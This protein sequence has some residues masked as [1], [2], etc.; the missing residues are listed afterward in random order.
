MR[1]INKR[2]LL[3]LKYHVNKGI[4][5]IYIFIA[6]ARKLYLFKRG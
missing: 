6:I 5:P 4:A 1:E 3:L 2:I